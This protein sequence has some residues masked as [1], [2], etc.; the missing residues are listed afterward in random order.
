MV[1]RQLQGFSFPL[2][3]F[4]RIVAYK[5]RRGEFTFYGIVSTEAY[6]TK[7]QFNGERNLEDFV[8]IL[9]SIKNNVEG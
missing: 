4:V 3:L 8:V 9:N 1:I 2:A 6:S 5:K 7:G